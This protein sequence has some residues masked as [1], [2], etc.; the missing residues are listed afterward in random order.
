[1][2]VVCQLWLYL[3]GQ[4]AYCKNLVTWKFQLLQHHTLQQRMASVPL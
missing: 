2:D 4:V 1:M 3:T